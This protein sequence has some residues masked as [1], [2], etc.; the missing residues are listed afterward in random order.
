MLY[1]IRDRPIPFSLGYWPNSQN[2]E[3]LKT[4]RQKIKKNEPN[5]PIFKLIPKVSVKIPNL[6][7]GAVRT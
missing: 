5:N 6:G 2:N 4:I 3:N 1:K 7:F